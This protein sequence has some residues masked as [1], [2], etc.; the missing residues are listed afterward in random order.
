[1]LIRGLKPS[2]PWP[3]GT[4]RGEEKRFLYDI[5]SNSRN[6][7]DVDK[8]DYLL[9]DSIAC[10]GAAGSELHFGV[11][12]WEAGRGRGGVCWDDST[13]DTSAGSPVS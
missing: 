9:R 13:R 7:L 8:L 3:D 11:L 4:G 12:G 2:E 1:M 5:V 6:G 10:F